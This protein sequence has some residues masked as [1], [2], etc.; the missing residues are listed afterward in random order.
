MH[1]PCS[2]FQP[3]TNQNLLSDVNQKNNTRD[4]AIYSALIGSMFLR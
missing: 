3:R 2:S 4:I 1:F